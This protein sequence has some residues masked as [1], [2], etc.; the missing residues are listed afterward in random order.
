MAPEKPKRR[1]RKK[2]TEP[3]GLEAN[4]LVEGSHPAP[5]DA[6]AAHIAEDGGAV[7]GIYKDPLGGSWQVIAALPLAKV[8]PTP[9]Q[10]DLSE[11]H[12]KKLTSAIDRL[13]RFLDPVIAIR[14]D[15]GKYWT[16]NGHHRVAALKELAARSVVALVVPEPEVAH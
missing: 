5:V 2:A 6:L 12:V 4:T 14:T 11:S 10:R 13:G 8:E 1:R 9:Y 15:E 7:I 3:R 16:P